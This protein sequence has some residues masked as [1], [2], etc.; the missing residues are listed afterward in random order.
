MVGVGVDHL[1]QHGWSLRG[2]K[3]A[4]CHLVSSP[5]AVP[6]MHWLAG[7]IGLK[8]SHCHEGVVPHYDLTARLRKMAVDFGA[9]ELSRNEFLHIMHQWKA[10]KR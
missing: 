10:M 4:S 6:R 5:E 8:R 3:V 9:Q 7:K 1:Q 2:R